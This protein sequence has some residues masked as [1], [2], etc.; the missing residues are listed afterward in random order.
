VLANV[1]LIAEAWDA[2]GLYQ[3]GR[4]PGESWKEWNG[5]F[6][7]DVRSFVKG[8]EGMARALA[9]RLLGSPDIYQYRQREPEVSI[10]FVTCH[11]GFTLNDVVSYND[12][13][14]EANRED[15]RDGAN[16]N[17][18]WNCGVEGPTD[19]PHVERLRNRQVKNLLALTLLSAG[20]PMLL[21]GD[22]VRR[23]QGG[24]NNAYC[25]DNEISW[26]DRSLV[27]RHADVRRFTH[28]LLALRVN[29]NLPANRL[30]MTLNELLH[31]VPIQW[32]GVKLNH[33]GWGNEARILAATLRMLEGRVLIHVMV[34]AYW[35]ALD[36]EVPLVAVG[37]APWRRCV[38]TFLDSPD[39]IRE[40]ADAPVVKDPVYWVQ[41]RSIVLLVAK[42]EDRKR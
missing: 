30:G 26:F 7:D 3:V 17:R 27:D 1:K 25:Q 35:E 20:T 33:P 29:R 19:D 21:M 42:D 15:N 28:M 37:R 6:R 16:D 24:N 9:Y 38:D 36:F 13:H 2:A 34:N 5:R 40:W 4:F 23:S 8:D 41:P 18:S 31:H 32:H 10:N 14:N 12:K 11:D 39:D 22:E